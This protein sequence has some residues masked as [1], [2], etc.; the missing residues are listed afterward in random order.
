MGNHPPTR[1]PLTKQ[2]SKSKL[3]MSDREFALMNPKSMGSPHDSEE[4]A[5]PGETAN[6]KSKNTSFKSTEVPASNRSPG[7][8]SRDQSPSPPKRMPSMLG[9]PL[10]N[11]AGES[12]PDE[13]HPDRK[14]FRLTR[15]MQEAEE[16][17]RPDDYH[18]GTDP[19][20][21]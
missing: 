15:K 18:P 8:P 14:D 9:P 10:S 16:Q 13:D 4:E 11:S 5:S 12:S 20:A 1:A 7:R 17:T 19:H 3:L 2:V 6:E 21:S